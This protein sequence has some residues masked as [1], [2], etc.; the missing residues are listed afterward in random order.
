MAGRRPST[1]EAEV[2]SPERPALGV[3]QA[4][5]VAAAGAAAGNSSN[6]QEKARFPSSICEAPID[7]DLG[8]L[9]RRFEA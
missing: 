2:G 6:Q 9:C 4:A 8:E 3:L 1:A 7:E 5:A